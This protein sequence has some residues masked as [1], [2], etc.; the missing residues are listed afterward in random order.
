MVRVC[1]PVGLALALLLGGCSNAIQRVD[2]G[3][4]HK[5]LASDPYA[6]EDAPRRAKVSPLAPRA[7]VA[8]ELIEQAQREEVARSEFRPWSRVDMQER[9]EFQADEAAVPD[10]R[11]KEASRTICRTC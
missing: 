8:R 9:E 7:A 1:V 3:E 2:L 4:W 6:G 10:R 11:L 5:F